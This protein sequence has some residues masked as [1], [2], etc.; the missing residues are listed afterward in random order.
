MKELN[1]KTFIAID[2][3]RTAGGIV[4][5]KNNKVSVYKIPDSLDRLDLFFKENIDNPETTLCM[6]E[7]VS[8]WSGDKETP[9]KDFRIQ[10]MLGHYEQLKTVL[11]LNKITV[12]ELAPQSWQKSLHLNIKGLKEESGV[13]KRR[14]QVAAQDWYKNIKVTLWNSDALL[15]HRFILTKMQLD[16]DWIWERIPLYK[17]SKIF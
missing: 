11:K 13:R 10:K 15:I 16:R 4:L 8:L 14:Y 17:D 5:D 7:R 1:F 3:G 12:I 6:I 9:G 2:P